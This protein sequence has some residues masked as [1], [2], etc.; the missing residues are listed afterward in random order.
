MELIPSIDLRQGRVVRLLRGDDGRRTLYDVDPLQTVRDHAAAGAARI[1]V[2]DLDAV[3][4][5]QPQR[6]LIEEMIQLPEAP[7]L[8]LGGGLRD[9]EAVEW[10]FRNGIDRVVVTSLMVREFELFRR[11]TTEYPGRMIAALDIEGDSLKLAGWREAAVEPWPEIA[12]RVG[13]LP[14][15][16]VLVTDIERDG[17]LGGPN[18]ELAREVARACSVG[19]LLSGG[20]RSLAD[21]ERAR[22]VPEIHGAIVGKALYDGAFSLADALAVSRGDR[23]A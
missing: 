16:A 6:S 11:L 3:F 17:T 4:G 12:A 2:V 22:E 9:R 1:H 21:L 10:A 5:E 14:L 20:I 7:P 13:P 15:A 8:Q 23:A 19:G 18:L